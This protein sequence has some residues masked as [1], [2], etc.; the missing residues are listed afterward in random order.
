MKENV[1][2]ESSFN[3]KWLLMVENYGGRNWLREKN[4]MILGD[5][6]NVLPPI[7]TA[8]ANSAKFRGIRPRMYIEDL[9]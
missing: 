7:G 2:N 5:K 9:L 3:I 4:E 1:P 6:R 8:L